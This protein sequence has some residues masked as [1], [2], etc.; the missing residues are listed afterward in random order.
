VIFRVTFTPFFLSLS[1]CTVFGTFYGTRHN[2][3][4]LFFKISFSVRKLTELTDGH[5]VVTESHITYFIVTCSNVKHFEKINYFSLLQFSSHVTVTLS[6]LSVVTGLKKFRI[7]LL[8]LRAINSK[9]YC[10]VFD[11]ILKHLK[12]SFDFSKSFGRLLISS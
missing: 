7:F 9:I 11:F 4:R 10:S 3:T 5:E 12:P 8:D 1:L 2:F 6:H